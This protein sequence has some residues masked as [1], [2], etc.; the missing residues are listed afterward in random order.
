MARADPERACA[1]PNKVRLRVGP[2]K[3]ASLCDALD[4]LLDTGAV[5]S[6][7]LRIRVADVDLIY[8]ALELVACSWETAM[9]PGST[10]GLER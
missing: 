7:D 5:V 4:S 8:V 2:G 1:T 10:V 6:G 3:S 9:G